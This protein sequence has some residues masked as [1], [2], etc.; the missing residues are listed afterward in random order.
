MN[1]LVSVLIP[2]YNRELFI[3]KTIESAI[4]QSYKNIEIIVVDNAST[5]GTWQIMELYAE[6]DKR[7]RIFRNPENIGPVLNWKKCIELARGQYAKILFSDDTM[8]VNFI[9]KSLTILSNNS[10]IA[11]VFCRIEL[12]NQEGVRSEIEISKS[13]LYLIKTKRYLRSKIF[14]IREYP[15][16]PGSAFFRLNDLKE[17]LLIEIPNNKNLVF[18][19]YGAGNDLLIFLLTAL[20]YRY[21]AYTNDT[22]VTFVGHLKSFSTYLN[23][24]EYYFEAKKNFCSSNNF[25]FFH[26][27]LSI[28]GFFRN[29]FK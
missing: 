21:V 4:N 16:S 13:A 28:V 3:A 1:Q 14:G 9:D 18:S 27:L 15:N 23:L 26:F 17:N 12:L 10:D 6:L 7:I 8:S 29:M 20:R 19:K 22:S 25:V 24:S 11:F 5:D 2:V